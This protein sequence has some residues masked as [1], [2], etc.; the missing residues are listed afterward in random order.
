MVNSSFQKERPI[1]RITA[2]G[3]SALTDSS[4]GG[5]AQAVESRDFTLIELLVVIAIIAILAAMLMPALEK[6][7]QSAQR[8]ACLSNMK[9]VGVVLNMY[10]GDYGGNIPLNAHHYNC[11]RYGHPCYKLPNG[12]YFEAVLP[13]RGLRGDIQGEYV[14]SGM[15]ILVAL[16]YFPWSY[17]GGK[18]FYCPSDDDLNY[19][20]YGGWGYGWEQKNIGDHRWSYATNYWTNSSY[21]YGASRSEDKYLIERHANRVAMVDYVRNVPKY[22][23]FYPDSKPVCNPHESGSYQGYNRLFFDGHANFFNDTDDVWYTHNIGVWGSLSLANHQ[24]NWNSHLWKKDLLD[25]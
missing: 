19:D 3:T 18:V 5:S 7:R 13:N 22:P 9:Q 10:A 12:T 21:V 16:D 8:I 14:Y 25:Q 6:A 4:N 20:E 11:T 1:M 24:G 2:A 15:G 23:Q 17:S